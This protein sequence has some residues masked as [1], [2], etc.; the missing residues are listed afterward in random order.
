MRRAGGLFG[1]AGD[2][3]HGAAQLFGGRRRF[4]D[5]AG[6]FLAGGS[7]A[8][9]DFLLTAGGG[10]RGALSRGS[11]RLRCMARSCGGRTGTA[12]CGSLTPKSSSAISADGPR[13]GRRCRACRIQRAAAMRGAI[14]GQERLFASAA[15]R[16]W[17]S[18]PSTIPT[19]LLSLPSGRLAE[20]THYEPSRTDKNNGSNMIKIR[21]GTAG[22]PKIAGK[23]A[24]CTRAR[25]LRPAKP[26]ISM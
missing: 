14:G 26:V 8:F 19:R 13:P 5:A 1:T 3:L 24:S 17:N 10:G 25:D 11:S 15:H 4:G 2:L 9:L 20:S 18:L 6:Q 16:P 12:L 7:D 23:I 21:A 22:K